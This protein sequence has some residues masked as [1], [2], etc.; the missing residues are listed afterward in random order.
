MLLAEAFCKYYMTANTRRDHI[1]MQPWDRAN[2]GI[3][4]GPEAVVIRASLDMSGRLHTHCS[5]E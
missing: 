5:H 1:E 2:S 3:A 4:A